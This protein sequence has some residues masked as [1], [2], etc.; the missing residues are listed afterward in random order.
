MA[1]TKKSVP[2]DKFAEIREE[3]A[4]NAAKDEE[5]R[6]VREPKPTELPTDGK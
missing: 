2:E 1:D 3:A 4:R 6:F 5:R